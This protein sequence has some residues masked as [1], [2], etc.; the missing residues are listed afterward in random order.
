MEQI[1]RL[2]QALTLCPSGIN[3]SWQ[4]RTYTISSSSQTDSVPIK[5]LSVI[6]SDILVLYNEWNIKLLLLVQ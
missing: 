6:L 2:L 5:S 1:L 4:L 3:I